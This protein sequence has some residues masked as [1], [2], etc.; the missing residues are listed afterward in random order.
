MP[1]LDLRCRVKQSRGL[2][3]NRREGTVAESTAHGTIAGM[4][5][6]YMG[7]AEVAAYLRREHGAQIEGVTIRQYAI[8]GRMPKPDVRIGPNA[9]WSEA[10]IAEWWANRP[11]RGART[12]LASSEPK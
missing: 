10:T 1:R 4:T 12:D 2:E 8:K 7:P 6:D 11:G 5:I 3:S 9:G